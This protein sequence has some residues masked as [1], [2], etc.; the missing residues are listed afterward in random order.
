MKKSRC[1]GSLMMIFQRTVYILVHQP[2]LN[3]T[4]SL[5]FSPWLK[6]LSTEGVQGTEEQ[7]VLCSPGWRSADDVHF[8]HRDDINANTIFDMY[9]RQS[10][11]ELS[12]RDS[13]MTFSQDGPGWSRHGEM[14]RQTERQAQGRP[15]PA[16]L[17]MLP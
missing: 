15:H 7:D 5:F 8:L 13:P 4:W 16:L 11:G 10:V 14:L 9:I 17:E 6:E 1:V 3:P 2:D 12:A